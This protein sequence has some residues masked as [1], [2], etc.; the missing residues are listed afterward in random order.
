[1][2]TTKK[3][4]EAVFEMWVKAVGGHVA[5]SYKDVDGYQL[6]HNSV[7]GGYCI[8]Q[9]VNEQGGQSDS[10]FLNTRLPAY[11]FVQAMRAAIRTVEQVQLNLSEVK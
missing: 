2:R 5:A 9:I 1:M 8:V 11:Y 6:D 7:Y 3:E 10:V 4:V